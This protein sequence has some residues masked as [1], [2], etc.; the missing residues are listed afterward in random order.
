MSGVFFGILGAG[1]KAFQPGDLG[2]MVADIDFDNVIADGS[3][4][5]LVSDAT[6]NYDATQDVVAGRP[7]WVE[8]WRAGRSAAQGAAGDV[9]QWEG[10]S[11]P[12]PYTIYAVGEWTPSVGTSEYIQDTITTRSIL[13]Q[14]AGAPGYYLGTSWVTGGTPQ[15]GGAFIARLVADGV[16][17][18]LDI[19]FEDGTSI[20]LSGDAGSAALTSTNYLMGR[21][22]SNSW[23]GKLSRWTAFQG[24]KSGSDTPMMQYL[25]TRYNFPSP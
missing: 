8:S 20:S 7:A 2:D 19:E 5:S 21:S 25:R 14:D 24:D 17:S 11:E 12:Q 10:M 13:G 22:S 1:G 15:R 6:G 16:S 18:K 4:I 23:L 3:G 9:L